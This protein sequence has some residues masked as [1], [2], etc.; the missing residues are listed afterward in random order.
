MIRR[1]AANV[2]SPQWTPE[3]QTSSTSVGLLG[4][5][6]CLSRS[7]SSCSWHL[8]LEALFVM[9]SCGLDGVLWRGIDPFSTP[10]LWSSSEGWFHKFTLNLARRSS[11]EM[12][13][14][15]YLMWLLDAVKGSRRGR[16]PTDPTVSLQSSAVRMCRFNVANCKRYKRTKRLRVRC[17]RQ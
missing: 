11:R 1:A 8:E 3:N 6:Y 16:I 2:D 10:L 15:K 7:R 17:R 5:E 9:L 13:C 4:S 12:A 14:L